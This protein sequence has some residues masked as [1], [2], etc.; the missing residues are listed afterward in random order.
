M[1]VF[2][3]QLQKLRDMMPA[4]DVTGL[5]DPA[6]FA[7]DPVGYFISADRE[8]RLIIWNTM[9]GRGKPGVVSISEFRKNRK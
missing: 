9:M 8:D 1:A 7:A 5:L 2:R 4:G 3:E 6:A